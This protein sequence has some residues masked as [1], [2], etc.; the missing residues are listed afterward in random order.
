MRSTHIKPDEIISLLKHRRLLLL[1]CFL[2][3]KKVRYT[4]EQAKGGEIR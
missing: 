1:A 3:L 4:V 2:R